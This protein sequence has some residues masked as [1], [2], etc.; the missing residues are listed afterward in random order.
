MLWYAAQ[1]NARDCVRQRTVLMRMTAIFMP[2]AD[3]HCL[4]MIMTPALALAALD[5]PTALC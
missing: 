5:S 2:K 3:V 4:Q 1:R